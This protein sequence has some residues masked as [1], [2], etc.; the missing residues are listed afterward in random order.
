MIISQCGRR[1]IQHDL[2]GT[3]AS[4]FARIDHVLAGRHVAVTKID[5]QLGLGTDHGYLI[6]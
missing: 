4:G 3:L 6:T 2:S 5:A 1:L